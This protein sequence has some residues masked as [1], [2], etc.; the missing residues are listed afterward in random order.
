MTAAPWETAPPE[1]LVLEPTNRCNLSCVFCCSRS[2]ARPLGDMD[3][4]LAGRLVAE[5]AALGCR[6][7][8][9]TGYGEPT[10]APDALGAALR[11]ARALGLRSTIYAN[12][13]GLP[14]VCPDRVIWSLDYDS[15]DLAAAIRPGLDFE[16]VRHNVEAYWRACGDRS[17]V[18]V[19]AVR[20]RENRDHVPAILDYWRPWC[21]D[22]AV[23]NE[24]PLARPEAEPYPLS[25]D[26]ACRRLWTQITVL[27][28]GR[29]T[30]CCCDTDGREVL[31]DATREPLR[32]IREGAAMAAL[33]ERVKARRWEGVCASCGFRYSETRGRT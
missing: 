9:A 8:L 18:T 27:W 28:D 31:G 11:A 17:R 12:G 23:E 22:V 25:A 14:P 10:L 7:L 13:T 33:R 5:A 16:R 2:Q 24:I 3:P 20:C 1:M 6:E 29:V 30:P 21:H 15:P 32:A 19:Q 26:Y 4:A